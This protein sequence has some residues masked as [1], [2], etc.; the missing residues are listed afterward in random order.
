MQRSLARGGR[1]APTAINSRRDGQA[2]LEREP[3]FRRD[4]R[5]HV[6]RRRNTVHDLGP[7]G[8]RVHKI[9]GPVLSGW[10]EE[11]PPSLTIIIRLA[12]VLLLL[13]WLYFPSAC[14]WSTLSLTFPSFNFED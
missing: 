7:L 10:C 8:Q 1:Q 12:F 11:Q 4:T 5:G 14:I 13:F 9:I 2:V 6:G 3:D